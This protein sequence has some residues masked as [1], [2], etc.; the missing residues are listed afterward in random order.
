MQFNIFSKMPQNGLSQT[1]TFFEPGSKS[2][3][4]PNKN[5]LFI[6]LF[7]AQDVIMRYYSDLSK[8]NFLHF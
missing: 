1:L 7:F 4:Y 5:S 6:E 8:Q 2:N 3:F